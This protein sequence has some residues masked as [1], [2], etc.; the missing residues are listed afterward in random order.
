MIYPLAL[1]AALYRRATRPAPMAAPV[2]FIEP[3]NAKGFTND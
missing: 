3:H 2:F 1:I